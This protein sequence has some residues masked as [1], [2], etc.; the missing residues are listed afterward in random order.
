MISILVVEDDQDL[1]Q[2]VC[3]VLKRHGYSVSGASSANEA[4]SLMF[5]N[6]FDLVI[7]DIMM[8][9]V[10]GFELAETIRQLDHNMPIMFMTARGDL[11]SKQIGF[12]IGIDDYMVKPIDFDEILLRV[13]A[14]LRRAKIEANKRL[15]IGK[16][17]MDAD[18]HVAY[19]GNESIAFTM[20][21][22]E[23][24][25]KLLSF[26]K[27]TFTRGQLMDD[28]WGIDTNTSTRTVDVYMTKIRDKLA[29]VNDFEIVTVRGLGYKAVPNES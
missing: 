6:K 23:L 19:N 25:F 10:D 7:S 16:F 21:E 29:D 4:F 2:T 13:G 14:L 12:R 26:P 8:P 1:N 15:T 22:F 20:R 24:V 17:V 5:D 9:K 28:F 3:S 11:E 27:K 18:E